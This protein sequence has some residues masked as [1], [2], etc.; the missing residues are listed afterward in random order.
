V[1]VIAAGAQDAS[2][3]AH[4]VV[5]AAQLRDRPVPGDVETATADCSDFT[6]SPH[7][8]RADGGCGASFLMCLGCLNA[9]LHPGPHP[10]LALLAEALDNLHS[11]LPTPVWQ[12]DWANTDARLHDL[13]NK[14]GEGPWRQARS[15]VTDRDR[16]IID[17]LLTGNLDT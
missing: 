4:Q 16:G 11:A 17:L 12:R 7:Q 10:R 14:I 5:L 13:A 1:E 8:R 3:R 9:R 2:D 15:R 6:G